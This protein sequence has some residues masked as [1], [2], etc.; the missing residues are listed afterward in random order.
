[1]FKNNL[2][3]KIVTRNGYPKEQI[4]SPEY[5]VELN[6]N[7]TNKFWN[8]VFESAYDILKHQQL[9]TSEQILTT[10]P[11]TIKHCP[12]TRFTP[13]P[14]RAVGVLFSPMVSEWAGGRREIVC[15]GCI[16]ET[17]RCRKLIL[18]RDIG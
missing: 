4:I 13:Q 14:L 12:M 2:V 7:I 15:P 17:I 11:N 1:M 16:S 5:I 18:G 8:N 9:L 3:Q 6:K 10:P